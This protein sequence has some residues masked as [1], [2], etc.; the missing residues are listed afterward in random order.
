MAMQSAR[1]P[2]NESARLRA[3][4]DLEILDTDAERS[5]DELTE[6]AASICGTPVSLV[7]LV[8]ADRQWFKSSH[9][10]ATRQTP[11]EQA[12]CAHAILGA[13]VFEV[14]D[15][16]EDVRFADN[17]LVTGPPNVVFYAGV[18]LAVE[19]GVNVGTLCVIDTERR[20]LTLA[21]AQGAALP[22]QPGQRQSSLAARERRA[23]GGAACER[24]VRRLHEP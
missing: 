2:A 11:R 12:F 7:S 20:R 5:F 15:A 19:P 23:P 18:P 22:R 1:V 8:A 6:L 16:R 13:D 9:G 10:L 21:R 3:L 17:P 24:G 14:E 4:H